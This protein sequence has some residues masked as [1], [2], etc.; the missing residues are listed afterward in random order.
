MTLLGNLGFGQGLFI[1]QYIETSSGSTPKGIEVFNN[2]G[3]DIVFSAGNN[4]QVYQGTNG[5]SCAVLPGINVTSG[6]LV[7]G[8]V[9][10]IGTTDLT[11]YAIANGTNLSG[12]TDYTFTFNGDDALELYLGGVLVDVFGTCGTDP[13]SSWSG[14]GVSTANN[15]LQIQS[16]ICSG[17]TS[18]WSDPSTR[19][20]QIAGGTTMTGFGDPP[21][22]CGSTPLLTVT[23]SILTGLD[24]VFGSGPSAS[25]SYD[26][27]GT[28]LTPASGNITITPPA[29][30]EFSFDNSTFY[31]T[32]QT[33]GYNAST[34]SSTTIY[35][36]L[37]S[38]LAVGTYG[39]SNITNAGG[40]ATTV[41]V[42]VDGEVTAPSAFCIDEDFVDF[43]DW[44]N[45]G[46][47]SDAVHCAPNDEC[48]AFGTGDDMITPPVDNPS[49]L[50]FM[51]DASS[52]GNG[53][54][55]TIDYKIGA[56]GTWTACHSFTVSK[57]ES[58]ES[59]DLTNIGGVNLSAEMQVYFR[60][61]SSFNTWYL[62]DVQVTCG[63]V[64]NTITTG[65]VSTSP[66][67]VDCTT[68]DGG[69]VAF[70]STD[71]F[72]SN[73]Y[74]AQLSD[75]SGSFAAPL[76]IG[77]LFSDANSGTINFVIP[78]G[79]PTGS[80]YLIR[81]I[82]NSPAV[83]GTS[84]AVFTINLSGGPCSCFEIESILVDAC[85]AGNE[86][87]NEM[88]RFSVGGNPID[89]ND[90]SV[91]W[92]NNSWLGLCQDATTASIV[93]AINAT[94]TG[95]GQLIEPPGGIIPANAEV[96]FFTSTDFNYTLFDFSALNYDLYAIFQCAG[97]TAG[98]FVNN[99]GNPIGTF[100]T[101][102]MSVAGCGSDAV[103][104]D[105]YYV[106]NGDGATVDFD[107]PGNPTYSP[108]GN[109]STVP[110][111]PVPIGLL[112][113]N[114]DCDNDNVELKWATS[115]ETNNDYFTVEAAL[116]TDDFTPVVKIEGAGNSNQRLQYSVTLENN[117]RYFRLKQTDF[118]GAFTY[119]PIEYIDCSN[120]GFNVY[121][122]LLQTGES[123]YVTGEIS[124]LEV[125]NILG[126]QVHLDLNENVIT[127]L[128]KGMYLVV[129]NRVHQFKV[130]VQ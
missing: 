79:T 72:T 122:T 19:F 23:P 91:N 62:D 117:Y 76:N 14:G 78:A 112:Y 103:T 73:T 89:V 54:T 63:T 42:A 107:I 11:A 60:F 100:R 4:L 110:I 64:S 26:L 46:T 8:E 75:A 121:P 40:G 96:M 93:S 32:A 87:E 17:T 53:N 74:T 29:N 84:S 86:G 92:P 31:T 10:V 126:M 114:S 47:A 3:A 115:S 123:V 104:Y 77:T 56:G 1:S 124:E 70:T 20:D 44:T 38:G 99:S 125:Y 94:I 33:V 105:A 59:V 95:G 128:E 48:R 81:V 69:T 97:N 12:T 80:G 22:G 35:V 129:I 39:S 61:N 108:G 130:I 98:H 55:A 119:S 21:I 5:A 67:S 113:F 30:F 82:S 24:Y 7:A 52:G 88:F 51:Q 37:V 50:E 85:D 101:L 16:G 118:D 13:G 25:Q 57:I 45:S 18:S 2:T 15:N 90:I 83:V 6:T 58:V 66:F 68:G 65:V 28:N 36:R 116:N 109:C 34:L 71:P 102:N 111:Y 49:L 9:W 127:G 106:F 41:N 43:S 27:S 120:S